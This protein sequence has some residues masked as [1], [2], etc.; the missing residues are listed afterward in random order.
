MSDQ[1]QL[2]SSPVPVLAAATEAIITLPDLGAIPEPPTKI[3]ELVKQAKES[4]LP[5]QSREDYYRW[6]K[7]FQLF[8]KQY[9]LDYVQDS[10]LIWAEHM[11]EKG[12]AHTTMYSMWSGIKAVLR[13]VDN[14]NAEKW[15]N[16]K[17]WLKNYASGKFAK[18][19]PAFTAEQV[20]KFLSSASDT[21]FIRQK[22]A[23]GLGLHGRLRA[24]EYAL[25]FH[26]KNEKEKIMIFSSFVYIL[27]GYAFE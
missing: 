27:Y 9:S 8:L 21:E 16:M 7:Q 20:H 4:L 25:L 2:P 18:S 19:A 22:L 1:T 6:Y 3:Q 14:I 10:A 13:R 23:L 24:S 11:K 5:E 26:N 15:D 12:A 17:L